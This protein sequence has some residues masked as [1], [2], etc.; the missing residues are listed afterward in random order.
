MTKSIYLYFSAI[1]QFLHDND[2]M[3]F[4]PD[5]LKNSALYMDGDI[6]ILLGTEFKSH[7]VLYLCH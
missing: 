3:I 5:S 6:C 1:C 4:F 7:S 2:I